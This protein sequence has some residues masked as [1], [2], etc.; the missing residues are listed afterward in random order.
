[1]ARLT[2]AARGRSASI[3]GSPSRSRRAARGWWSCVLLLLAAGCGSPPPEPESARYL[4]RLGGVL[5]REIEPRAETPGPAY[6]RRRDL[7]IEIPRAE[8]DV[9]EFI[10]LHECDMGSLVGLRNSPL[11]RTQ[12][13]SQRLGYEAAWLQAAQRCG[14]AAPEWLRERAAVKV[15][16]IPALYWNAVFAGE[17]MRIAAGGAR[18]A[19]E[20]DF[21]DVIAAL[22]SHLLALERGTF[23]LGAFEST[24][25]TLA[26]GG[27]IGRARQAWSIWRGDLDAARA[28]LES[29]AGRICRN[30]RPTPRSRYLVNVFARY[31]VE[32]LQPRLAARMRADEAWIVAMDGLVR[33]LEPSVA[34]A[35][36]DWFA[37]VLDPQVSGSEWSRTRAAVLAH[38]RAWQHVFAT[39]GI[40][41]R[42]AVRHD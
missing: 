30:G 42:S 21:A 9:G 18:P 32:G 11:G 2:D 6:P 41:P 25:A 24:L 35:F 5:E 36:R 23:E 20:S 34:P 3:G 7:R 37:H 22:G 26:G 40:D 10:E 31:Y 13:A 17:E 27:R 8:I 33:R 16:Q 15:A 29:E 14:D 28:A 38:A 1:M 4:Q 39:C 12:G 19:P